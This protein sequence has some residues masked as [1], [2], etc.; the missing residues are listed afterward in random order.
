MLS[1]Y[2]LML[3]RDAKVEYCKNREHYYE[4]I[5]KC[6]DDVMPHYFSIYRSL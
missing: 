6:E 5:L 3:K 1:I 2:L 4:L